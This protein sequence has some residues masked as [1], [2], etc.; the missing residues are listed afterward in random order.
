MRSRLNRQAQAGRSSGVA[1]LAI[2]L[3]AISALVMG[4]GSAPSAGG[5]VAFPVFR[6]GAWSLAL[7]LADGSERRLVRLS[8]TATVDAVAWAPDGKRI[9]Y[10][11]DGGPNVDGGRIWVMNRDGSDRRRIMSLWDPVTSLAWS[12]HEPTLAYTQMSTSGIS[13]V[14]S[15]GTGRRTLVG[16]DADA[17]DSPNWSPNGGRVFFDAEIGD[18]VEGYASY[19]AVVNADGS[20]RRLLSRLRTTG[21]DL[22]WSPNGEQ[23]AFWRYRSHSDSSPSEVY[24]MNSDGSGVRKITRGDCPSWSP[25]SKRIVFYR[26]TIWT[27]SADGSDQRRL[28]PSQSGASYGCPVWGRS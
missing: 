7:V 19:L 6:H 25:D 23:I 20:G 21:F 3:L 18:A 15:D 9:A 11:D 16:T 1:P 10:S 2:L 27:M 13:L 28:W 17:A 12:P 4:C 22:T 26:G 14:N 8:P 24:T 5:K